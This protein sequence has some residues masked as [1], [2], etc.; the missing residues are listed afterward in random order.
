[1][2][3][4]P[5]GRTV[6]LNSSPYCSILAEVFVN[7]FRRLQISRFMGHANPSITLGIYAHLFEDDHEPAMTALAAMSR[8]V[9]R[10]GNVIP[11]RG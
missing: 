2:N 4:T 10:T 9:A 3:T 7:A 5:V 11:L 8:P 6:T 1:M